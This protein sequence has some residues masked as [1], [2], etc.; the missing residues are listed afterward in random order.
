MPRIGF[1][2]SLGSNVGAK[3]MSRTRRQRSIEG[4]PA[5]SASARQFLEFLRID[6]IDLL[7]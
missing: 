3:N 5:I 4:P 2:D 7:R 6:A 1:I